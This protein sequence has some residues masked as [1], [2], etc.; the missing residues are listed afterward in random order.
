M[1]RVWCTVSMFLLTAAL[2][3]VLRNVSVWKGVAPGVTAI[4]RR[5]AVHACT[6]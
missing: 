3:S 4:K 2:Q 5:L 1:W 6:A